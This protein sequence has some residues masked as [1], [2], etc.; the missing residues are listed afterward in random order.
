MIRP[1]VLNLSSIHILGQHIW[2][3]SLHCRML[4]ASRHS[5]S[6]RCYWYPGPTSLPSYCQMS[7]KG[8]NPR[9]LRTTDKAKGT[10]DNLCSHSRAIDQLCVLSKLKVLPKVAFVIWVMRITSTLHDCCNDFN[11][12]YLCNFE[13]GA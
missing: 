9:W 8:Q 4:P 11:R 7:R 13:P 1:G 12:G 2:V 3:C 6:P 10:R 5:L